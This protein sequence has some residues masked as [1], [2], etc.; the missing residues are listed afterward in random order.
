M[1]CSRC[2]S[3]FFC[4]E[5]M[6]HAVPPVSPMHYDVDQAGAAMN[7]FIE[8]HPDAVK[9]CTALK[10]AHKLASTRLPHVRR[11]VLTVRGPARRRLH[12]CQPLASRRLNLHL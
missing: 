7:F 9:N 4:L 2:A 3:F 5:A 12:P 10:A 11:I 1:G 8:V 6:G